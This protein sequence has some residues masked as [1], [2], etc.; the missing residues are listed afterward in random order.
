MPNIFNEIWGFVSQ[1]NT[2]YNI[3]E[4]WTLEVILA[5][6]LKWTAD[7]IFH[8]LKAMTALYCVS[9]CFSTIEQAFI[10]ENSYTSFHNS[11]YSTVVIHSTWSWNP[12]LLNPRTSK[13]SLENLPTTWTQTKA[14]LSSNLVMMSR[15]VDLRSFV[16]T[17]YARISA[18]HCKLQTSYPE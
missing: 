13:K 9:Q 16:S 3:K 2:Y 11:A 8:I 14:A 7:F 17:Q 18:I 1:E 5:I 10:V 12:R 15:V 4:A 6:N